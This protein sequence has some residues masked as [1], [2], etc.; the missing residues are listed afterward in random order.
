[1]GRHCFFIISESEPAPTIISAVN[2]SS[3]MAITSA[4]RTLLVLLFLKIVSSVQI[5][6]PITIR[7]ESGR[8]ASVSWVSPDDGSL[9]LMSTP[10]IVSGADFDLKSFVTHKFEVK[11][12]PSKSTGECLTPGKCRVEYFIVSDNLDQGELYEFKL[13]YTIHSSTFRFTSVASVANSI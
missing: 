5:P 10:D 11:E 3:T 7:N 9:H 6:R 13:W 4:L 2:S 12:L 8:R 1:M